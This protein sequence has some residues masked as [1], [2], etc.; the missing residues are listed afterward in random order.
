MLVIDE[1]SQAHMTSL[2]GTRHKH[3]KPLKAI[4]IVSLQCTPKIRG[5]SVLKLK[6]SHVGWF[7]VGHFV[8]HN[9]NV[10]DGQFYMLIHSV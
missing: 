7:K 10:L 2:A 6:M 5:I 4:I 1:V 9:E 8:G 3:Q